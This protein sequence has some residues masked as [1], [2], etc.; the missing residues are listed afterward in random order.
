[1]TMNGQRQHFE[2][3]LNKEILGLKLAK[4]H[5]DVYFRQV[6]RDDPKVVKDS[7]VHDYKRIPLG[8]VFCMRHERH[9]T[10]WMSL[11]EI[12]PDGVTI[13]YHSEFNERSFGKNLLRIDEGSFYFSTAHQ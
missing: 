9:V 3:M 2:A 6:C 10:S 4:D 13:S 12:K 8:A 1:M 5:I 11:N 7:N